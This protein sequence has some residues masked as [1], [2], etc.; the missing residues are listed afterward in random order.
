[1]N[2]V[3]IGCGDFHSVALTD[4]GILFTWGGGGINYNKGQTG[5]GNSDDI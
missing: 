4:T 5:H 2:V 1:M 3:K